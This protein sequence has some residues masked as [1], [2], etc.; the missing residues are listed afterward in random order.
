[1]DPA[2]VSNPLLVTEGMREFANQ[3]AGLGTPTERLDRLQRALFNE[4]TFPFSY[5]NRGTFTA[6][7]AFYRR[8]GNCL[9]FTNLFVALGRSLNIPV[10]TALVTRVRGSE[11]EG[12]LIV[13]NT[14]VIAVLSYGGGFNL[15]DFERSRFDQPRALLSL[16]DMWITALYLNNRGAEELRGGRTESSRSFFANAVK[17]ADTFAGAWGNL[18][19]A[20][21]RLGDVNGA[22]AA[23][24]QAL[25]IEP[26]NPTILTNLAAV[27]RSIDKEAEALAALSAANM[28]IASPHVLLVRGDLEL[29]QGNIDGAISLYRSARNRQ[30]ALADAWVSM[31]RAELSRGRESRAERYLKKALKLDPGNPQAQAL[32]SKFTR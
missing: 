16:D 6:A 32:Q 4:E 2:E 17:L 10:T 1:V 30:P 29:A 26:G 25:A 20:R 12:D 11:R 3:A 9:S 18:G 5:E 8:Q 22:L 31:A 28:T 19:V 21:R 27:Y 14:H 15:Y 23:Y 7:E 24:A 13:V